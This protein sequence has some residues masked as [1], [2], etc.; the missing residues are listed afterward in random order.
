MKTSLVPE[1]WR[2][3]FASIVIGLIA[4][5]PSQAA[6][7]TWSDSNNWAA[8]IRPVAGD[9]VLFSAGGLRPLNQN[10]LLTNLHTVTFGSGGYTIL[11]NG[12]TLATGITAT[13]SE[14]HTS[15]LQS[16]VD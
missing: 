14:E 10:D 8:N 6:V 15:E 4:A 7:R 3:P 12:P 1:R 2:G 13:R 16:R 11:G 9:D 5:G